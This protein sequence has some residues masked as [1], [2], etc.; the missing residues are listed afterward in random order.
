M[1]WFGKPLL[2]LSGCVVG[3]IVPSVLG[4]AKIDVLGH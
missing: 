3:Y 4:V 1:L 2:D